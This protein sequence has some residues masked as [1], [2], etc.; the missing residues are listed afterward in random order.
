MLASK[1]QVVSAVEMGKF[2]SMVANNTPWKCQCLS[3]ALCVKWLLNRYKIPSVF[4]FGSALEKK[5]NKT[6]MKAHAWIDV[7][8]KT[9]IGGP[10]HQHYKVVATFTTP[11]V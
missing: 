10:Q 9:V 5:D 4:Y 1:E 8:S 6:H 2:M 7:G 3:Q 11:Q